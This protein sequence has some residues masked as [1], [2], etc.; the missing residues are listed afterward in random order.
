MMKRLFYLVL[1]LVVLA[2]CHKDGAEKEEVF[3]ENVSGV[4]FDMV[5]VKAGSFM[6][7]ASENDE[8]VFDWEMPEHQVT[9]TK[10][11]YIG[12]HEV[13]QGLWK[14][15]MGNNPSN[16]KGDDYPVEKVSWDNIQEFITK[17]NELTGKKYAL[18]T[19]AQWEY[20]ARGGKKNKGYKY[21]GSN[22]INEV[23][24]YSDNSEGTTHPV[25]LKKANELGLYDM[26]GNVWEWCQDWYDDYSSEAQ[27]D[28]VGPEEGSNC[29]YRGGSWYNDARRC[30]MSFRGYNEPDERYFYLGFRLVLLP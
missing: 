18:P 22:D 17:L 26:T 5:Y 24:W 8:E 20:A 28:P 3:T 27:I 30:R 12:K 7:G 29:V 9:L 10:D 16:F 1:G 15:V 11:Y 14:A 23:A 25:G 19:E 2:G 13:T 4:L 21:S 6:M